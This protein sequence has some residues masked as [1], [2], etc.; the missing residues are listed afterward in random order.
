M[1]P[2]AYI[3]ISDYKYKLAAPY[4]AAWGELGDIALDT[5]W[6]SLRNGV[7]TVAA[8]YAW[9]GPSGP[10]L[11]TPA[12]MRASLE[13]D[14]FYQMI[15]AGDLPPET[16]ALGDAILRRRMEEYPSRFKWW[17]KV[18]AAYFFRCVRGFGASSAER[19]EV[20]PQDR[21]ITV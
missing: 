13:H 5:K 2:L 6:Y 15:R 7:L 14:V 19:R 1:S 10:T 11:D 9:D 16:R 4:D 17:A 20:E 18:R 12:T 3:D 21:I 8:G